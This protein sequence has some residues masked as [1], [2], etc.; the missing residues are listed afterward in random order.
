MKSVSHVLLCQPDHF[1]VSYSIN[2]WM[3]PGQVN[4]LKAQQQWKNLYQTLTLLGIKVE[5]IPQ[6]PEV[7]DMVFAVDQGIVNDSQVLLASFHYPERQ[8][9]TPYYQRWFED[10]GFE[11]HTLSDCY[12]EGGE[13]LYWNDRY[14]VGTGFRTQAEAIPVLSSFLNT[15]VTAL[16]LI[17][18]HF[19]HL[20]M[21]LL[22]LSD[23]QV[24]YYPAAFS[25]ASIELLQHTVPE[26]I[27]LS[28][29]EAAL[30][31]ANSLVIDKTVLL[32]SINPTLSQKLSQLGYQPLTVDVSEFRKAGGGIHCLVMPL[33]YQSV[34]TKESY[35]R[36][37]VRQSI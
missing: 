36:T 22:P 35:D 26:L 17:D 18:P 2:P 37:V 24:M 11:V 6:Q 23:S 8:L 5:V 30:F 32:S 10:H 21:C 14:F 16:E 1:Q 19:Y 13:Y 29:E 9:E 12:F 15:T 31:G 33:E 20:D 27:V 7:P 3:Q 28:N 34:V 4:Q 25:S